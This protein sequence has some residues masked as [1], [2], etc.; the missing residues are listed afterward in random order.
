MK[1]LAIT[2]AGSDSSGGAGLEADLKSF[3][4][5][6]IDGISVATTFVIQTPDKVI[7][8]KELPIDCVEE[9]LKQAI[10]MRPDVVKVG[11]IYKEEIARCVADLV[12]DAGIE[13][14]VVDPIFKASDGT[15][16]F[17]GNYQK[18]YLHY[19]A[20]ISYLFTPNAEEA[21]LL[22]GTEIKN[23]E[24]IKIASQKFIE[25]GSSY[26]L[27]K[28]GHIK[29]NDSTDYLR[30]KDLW[31]KFYAPRIE[32]KFHGT[33][34]ALSSLIAGYLAI[35]YS[36]EEA[37]ERSKRILV[38]MMLKGRTL[39]GYK[40]KL[41]QFFPSNIDIP[42]S[43][44][45]ERYK[46]WLELREALEEISK[47][48]K[49]ELIPEVGINFGFALPDAKSIEDICAISGRIHSIEDIPNRYLKF[50]ASKHV[51]TV[52]LTAMKF[53]KNARSAINLAYS[54][55]LIESFKKS[56][57]LVAEFDRR[58]EPKNS[59]STME[60]GIRSVIEKVRSV[61]D[62]V[63]DKGWIGKEPMVRVIGK[64]PKEIIKKLREAIPL[65]V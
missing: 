60:W 44:E 34:C 13:K 23:E 19:L 41:L 10:S 2:I 18:T 26:V 37:I 52:I 1:K 17:K 25:A 33:G 55:K 7:S 21:S 27:I 65:Q 53:D 15:L 11:V 43:L 8:I 56:S 57:F 51:A 31:R 48:L 16:L 5:V 61:P 20:P 40:S 59:K 58:E 47:M 3:S 64:N 30:G 29:G 42:P 32:G 22:A 54:E 12:I 24:D 4:Y 46:V 50:G 35:G 45:E 9:H 63:F 6:G 49:P 62:V 28:G 36:I 39:K 14:V 38:G